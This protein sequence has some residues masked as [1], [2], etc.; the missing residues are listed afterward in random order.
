M[1]GCH[2]ED[3]MLSNRFLRLLSMLSSFNLERVRILRFLVKVRLFSAIIGL[4]AIIALIIATGCPSFF[5]K[6]NTFQN[7]P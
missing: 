6:M 7:S 5:M 2:K 1:Q 3:N 4:S